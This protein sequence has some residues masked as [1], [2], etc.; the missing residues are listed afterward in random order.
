[1]AMLFQNTTK[2][3]EDIG[4]SAYDAFHASNDISREKNRFRLTVATV[5]GGAIFLLY[6]T[7]L[8]IEGR[9][10]GYLARTVNLF[11]CLAI[12]LAIAEFVTRKKY[13]N[14]VG[15]AKNI[16]PAVREIKYSFMD[17]KI[18]ITENYNSDTI[19]YNQIAKVTHDQNF[20]YIYT[21]MQKLRIAKFGFNV[22]PG[23]FEK[24][25]TSYGFTISV[26][27]GQY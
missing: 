22:N 16:Q 1:M 6:N 27:Y 8:F 20:Y 17:D 18:L 5:V 14:V 9:S 10:M 19:F 26:E 11:I 2:I 21:N 3:S 12:G 7:K 24:L 4:M 23:E 25:M 15:A 13:G